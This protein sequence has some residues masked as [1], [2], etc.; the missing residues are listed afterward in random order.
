MIRVEPSYVAGHSLGLYAALAVSGA[1]RFGDGLAMVERARAFVRAACPPGLFGMA[2]VMTAS[3]S[4]SG[5]LRMSVSGSGR[6]TRGYVL[7]GEAIDQLT[8]NGSRICP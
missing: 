6:G 8:P 7:V 5:R 1:V 4:R 3:P 2:V